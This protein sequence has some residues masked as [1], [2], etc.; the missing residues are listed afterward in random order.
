MKK[1]FFNISFCLLGLTIL[2]QQVYA[3]EVLTTV[4]EAVS[5]YTKGDYDGAASNLDYAAQLIRQKKSE[6]LKEVF[7]EPF[8]GWEAEIATSQATGTAVFGKNISVSRTYERKP[9]TVTIDI[10]S[11]S[12]VMQSLIMML[13]NPVIAGAGGAKLESFGIHKGIVQYK[14][15]SR[16]GDVN[17]VI[18]DKF[19]VTVKGQQVEREELIAY[20][21]AVQYSKLAKKEL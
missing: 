12:P 5:Q 18:D 9:S 10:V 6:A 13:N 21:Q 3:D 1:I 16:S 14:E 11:D 8:V 2:N 17:I 7:P 4:D 15:A 20:A 19:M